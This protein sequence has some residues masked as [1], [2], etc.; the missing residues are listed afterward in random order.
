MSNETRDLNT[1][2]AEM[3]FNGGLSVLLVGI[4]IGALF[5]FSMPITW[6]VALSVT[7]FFAL[8][9]IVWGGVSLING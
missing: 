8:V 1:K 9:L 4:V 2:R 5:G 3:A 6:G 7:V